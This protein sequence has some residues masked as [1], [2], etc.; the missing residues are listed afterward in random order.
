MLSQLQSLVASASSGDM[1]G[2]AAIA[3]AIKAQVQSAAP[4]ETFSPLLMQ[5]LAPAT[6]LPIFGCSVDPM[7]M[8]MQ[9]SLLLGE[10]RHSTGCANCARTA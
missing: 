5:M 3:Q 6:G 2:A 8:A 1:T 10:R 9:W 4:P 7:L